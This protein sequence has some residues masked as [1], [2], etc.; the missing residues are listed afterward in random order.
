[1]TVEAFRSFCEEGVFCLLLDGFDEVEY[2]HREELERQILRISRRYANCALILTSRPAERF[3]SWVEFKTYSCVPFTYE[4]FHHLISCAPFD[5]EAKKKF[6]KLADGGFFMEHR[7]FI[8]NPLLAL[9]M[10]MTFRDHAEIPSRLATFYKNCFL[11]LYSKHDALKEQFSRSKKLDQNDFKRLFGS[12]CFLTYLKSKQDFSLDEVYF[13]IE[14]A[15][16]HSQC[17]LPTEDILYEFIEAIN[18]LYHEGMKYWFVHRSFQ[19]YFAAYYATKVL[20]KDNDRVLDL[21]AQRRGDATLLLSYQLHPDLVVQDF[22]FPNVAPFRERFGDV[23]RKS[24]VSRYGYI[25]CAE[26]TSDSQCARGGKEISQSSWGTEVNSL[27]FMQDCERLIQ[28]IDYIQS[29]SDHLSNY[30]FALDRWWVDFFTDRQL[31]PN[32]DYVMGFEVAPGSIDF[33]LSQAGK[34][35]SREVM[36]QHVSDE[37]KRLAESIAREEEISL[38]RRVN[39]VNEW[40]IEKE[41]ASK[42]KAASLAS[43]FGL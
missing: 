38:R 23:L 13:F 32:A 18:L 36:T 17:K 24:R 42:S 5:P 19:E 11:T 21:F 16:E 43:D 12:F 37:V 2:R 3:A 35:S 8:S 26:F 20:T 14:R 29:H 39:L 27:Q 4:K 1:M 6:L 40:I 28:N 7:D 31:D 9:M 41:I 15:A 34:V 33:W 30:H 25:S 22:I 10:L